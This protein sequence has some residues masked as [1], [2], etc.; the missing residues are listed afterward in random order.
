MSEEG[1]VIN[2]KWVPA[3][4]RWFRF[5]SNGEVCDLS[6]GE[7]EVLIG[8]PVAWE[9]TIEEARDRVVDAWL[10]WAEKVRDQR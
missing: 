4:R 3:P 7:G 1:A 9:D 2:G 10:A 8:I 5:G 6:D